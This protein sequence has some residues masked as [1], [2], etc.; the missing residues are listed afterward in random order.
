M[1]NLKIKKSFLFCLIATLVPVTWFSLTWA[2]NFTIT[3]IFDNSSISGR[4]PSLNNKGQI[5]YVGSKDSNSNRGD[6][7]FFDGTKVTNLTAGLGL[8]ASYPVINEQG[9]IAF[10]ASS[11]AGYDVYFYDGSNLTNITANLDLLYA[12]APSLNNLGQIAFHVKDAA[13]HWDI[14]L[15][16]GTTLTNVTAKLNQSAYFPILNN[17]GQ[18]AFRAQAREGRYEIYFYNGTSLTKLTD[19]SNI[20]LFGSYPYFPEFLNLNDLGQISFRGTTPINDY[21]GSSRSDLYFYDG[22]SLRNLSAQLNINAGNPS[23]NDNG[24]IAFY[25]YQSGLLDLH[26]YDGTAIKKIATMPNISSPPGSLQLNNKGQVA[27][28]DYKAQEDKGKAKIYL[29]ESGSPIRIIEIEPEIWSTGGLQ[30]NDNGQIVFSSIIYWNAPSDIYFYDGTSITSITAN[31]ILSGYSSLNDQGQLAFEVYN[32]KEQQSDIYLF[33][34]KNVHNIT[35][36][37]DARATQPS[38][39]EAGQ[40]AFVAADE[41]GERSNI[42]LYD[43]QNISNI[44][45]NLAVSCSS[46]SLN[47]KGQI[48]FVGEDKGGG[49]S[50]IYLYDGSTIRNITPDLNI[51]VSSPDLNDK[52]EIAFIGDNN[53]YIYAGGTISKITASLTLSRVVKLSLNNK[54]Q[55]AFIGDGSLYLYDW[56][57]GTEI[58]AHYPALK[59][60]ATNAILNDLGDIAFLEW[61]G[62]GIPPSLFFFYGP[63]VD[64]HPASIITSTSSEHL[65]LNNRDQITFLDT[66]KNTFYLVNMVVNHPP[67]AQTGPD[68][69]VSP[70]T[71]VILNGSG[72]YDSDGDEISYQWYIISKP[73]GSHP[74]LSDPS[75]VNSGFIADA[76]GIYEVQL[77][78]SDG[79]NKSKSDSLL[80]KVVTANQ[81]PLAYAGADLVVSTGF[82]VTLDGS[83]SYNPGKNNLTYSWS[84]VSKPE[85][86][87]ASL[88]NTSAEKT[89]FQAD[90][91]GIY[92]V[93]LVVEN[94][95]SKSEPD[96][97]T[98][99]APGWTVATVA[100][101]VATNKT[102]YGPGDTLELMVWVAGNESYNWEVDAF[103]GFVLPDRKLYFLDPTLKLIP[104]DNSDPRTFTPFAQNVTLP[105]GSVFPS[106]IE[107]DTDMDGNG[108]L[109]SY[110]LFSVTLPP[111]LPAGV[112]FA[113]AALIKPGSV[114]A[115]NPQVFG[116]VS[117]ASF[118]F[119]P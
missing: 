12:G 89:S 43:G 28:I 13:D 83:G 25:S 111:D 102:H 119:S 98:I 33:D 56:E 53:V 97:I 20:F 69:V 42:Y 34:G 95:Q 77:L 27:F 29:Y 81:K 93:Q 5:A 6:I 36:R 14:Y 82:Q 104:G 38:M 37:F 18:M 107:M 54:G 9:Q 113:F 79:V 30:F 64:R 1:E 117:L 50:D 49:I 84:M 66:S 110:R 24:Q 35:E 59:P 16:N 109:D 60:F 96:I 26:F 63:K 21:Y 10:E 112:Y 71:A 100:I 91:A 15:Y 31:H 17:Q 55:I 108:K 68:Q 41:L 45:A 32:T 40:I 2:D 118:I 4:S 80:I 72:S 57:K 52:G 73:R 61:S 47:N 114:Q 85:N 39:N 88:S 106:P 92:R 101:I 75:L 19:A 116:K 103:I 86:S 94:D 90:I 76:E 70:G 99:I 87:N 23:L 8:S 46:P 115:G 3:P 78:V 7:Y 22:R 48:A 62:A 11:P 44:T 51:K 67:V 74:A 105:V 58:I 65:S